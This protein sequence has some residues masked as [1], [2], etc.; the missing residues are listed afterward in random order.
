MLLISDSNQG[1]DKERTEC[2]VV[3]QSEMYDNFGNE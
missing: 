3:Q 1:V 2:S